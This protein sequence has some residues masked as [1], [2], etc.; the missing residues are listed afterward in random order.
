MSSD[1]SRIRAAA[2]RYGH[3]VDHIAGRYTNPVTGKRLSGSALLLKI[4]QGE[5]SALTSDKARTDVS[6]AGARAWMQ[7]MPSSRAVAIQKYGV[8]PWRTPEEAVRAATLHLRGKING[9][10]G[11]EGYN[12]GSS[13]YPNYILG[14]RV[15]ATHEASGSG[16]APASSAAPR[17]TTSSSSSSAA[18]S[19]MPAFDVVSAPEAVQAPVVQASPLTA[20]KFAAGP[21]MPAGY[22]APVSGGGP[23]AQ[24]K[25]ADDPLDALPTETPVLGGGAEFELPDVSLSGE[26]PASGGATAPGTR[27]RGAYRGSPVP[28]QKPQRS[29]HNTDGLPGYPAFDYMAPAGKSVVAPVGGKVIRLS[30]KD[31]KLGGAPGGALGYSVYIRGDDGKTYFLTHIDRVRPKVGARVRQGQKIAVVANGP[32]SWSTPHVHMGVKG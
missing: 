4:A 14:Q 19:A 32:S 29:T 25:P 8:D 26:S 24:E 13:T 23:V 21:T 30:G 10:T 27:V 9:K 2:D 28:G 15:G 5:S 22:Q 17:T 12:P 1:A 7:F 3:L 20:P 11:L 16:G 31:P 6:S 18:A